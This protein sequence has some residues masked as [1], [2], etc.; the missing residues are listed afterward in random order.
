MVTM[1][2]SRSDGEP[3]RGRRKR[4]RGKMLL[5]R[6]PGKSGTASWLRAVSAFAALVSV[7]LAKWF[8]VRSNGLA[9]NHLNAAKGKKERRTL[10]DKQKTSDHAL[11]GCRDHQLGAVF[12][13][14]GVSVPIPTARRGLRYDMQSLRDADDWTEFARTHCRAPGARV[15]AVF[16]KIDPDGE[17]PDVKVVLIS[18][19]VLRTDFLA[20]QANPTSPAKYVAV[21][22]NRKHMRGHILGQLSTVCRQGHN[23][24]LTDFI[25]TGSEDAP[26]PSAWLTSGCRKP[27]RASS[28]TAQ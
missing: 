7:C 21:D 11:L 6:I 3:G 4:W 8:C 18:A 28:S 13:M 23:H 17:A 20:V 24:P 5:S 19:D 26:S 2:V 9:H 27:M 15:V 16:E 12:R 10:A 25:C 14:L 1:Q 22:A